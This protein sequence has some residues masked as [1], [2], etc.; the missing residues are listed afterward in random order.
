MNDTET[1]A[2]LESAL[3]VAFDTRTQ[4]LAGLVSAA[5]VY[6]LTVAPE[7]AF[8]VAPLVPAYHWY[9]SGTAP[10]AVTLRTA[11]CP[12][13]TVAFEGPVALAGGVPTADFQYASSWRNASGSLAGAGP[14]ACVSVFTPWHDPHTRT[15]PGC[16]VTQ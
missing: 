3:P 5:V 6:A 2:V 12:G 15:S 11:A 10:V 8:E 16:I 13:G 1:R 9:A 14:P 4:Y 7:M